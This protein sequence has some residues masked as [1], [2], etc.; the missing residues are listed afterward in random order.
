ML[1][2]PVVFEKNVTIDAIL[3]SGASA[4]A[5]AQSELDGIKQQ[6][7]INIFKTDELPIL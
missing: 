7:P 1:F 5:I 3:D 6:A 2:V 4:S